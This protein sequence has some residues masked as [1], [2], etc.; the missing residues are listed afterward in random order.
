MSADQGSGIALSTVVIANTDLLS[1]QLTETESVMLDVANG[2]YFGVESV[3]KTI[4]DSLAE[5]RTIESICALVAATYATD[6]VD[7]EADTLEFV[8]QLLAAGLASVVV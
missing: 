7:V 6:D 4:W 2:S 8:D 3:A 5:A 1:T